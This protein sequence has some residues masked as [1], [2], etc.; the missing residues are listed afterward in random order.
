MDL[1][2]P[3][4]QYI[5]LIFYG[6]VVKA[7]WYKRT[8]RHTIQYMILYVWLTLEFE[9]YNYYFILGSELNVNVV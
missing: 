6:V 2:L 7:T 1:F 8:R 4:L 9:K 3:Y 5:Q